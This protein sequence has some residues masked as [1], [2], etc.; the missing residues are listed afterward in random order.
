MTTFLKKQC[1]FATA[2]DRLEDVLDNMVQHLF[3]WKDQRCAE[4]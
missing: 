1:I 2:K 4:P 3:P